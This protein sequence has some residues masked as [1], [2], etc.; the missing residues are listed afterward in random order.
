[1]TI[2][3]RIYGFPTESHKDLLGR[4]HPDYFDLEHKL[5]NWNYLIKTTNYLEDEDKKIAGNLY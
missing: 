5:R 3:K 4:Q 1:M 2:P